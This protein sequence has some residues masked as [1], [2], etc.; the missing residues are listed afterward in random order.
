MTL[1]VR[2]KQS[3][4]LLHDVAEFPCS[5]LAAAGDA[6]LT[7]SPS[8]CPLP[9]FP[10]L[11]RTLHSISKEFMGSQ[12]KILLYFSFFLPQISVT[13]ECVCQAWVVTAGDD[14]APVSVV[15]LHCDSPEQLIESSTMPTACFFW[16]AAS[17]TESSELST[18]HFGTHFGTPIAFAYLFFSFL[19]SSEMQ[20][21]GTL[22]YSLERV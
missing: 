4:A 3:T 13:F 1:N 14:G 2:H 21:N 10:L 11:R 18:E 16:L 8:P 5:C 19:I 15:Y 6:V 7:L 17:A 22:Y 12:G 9:S 20:H